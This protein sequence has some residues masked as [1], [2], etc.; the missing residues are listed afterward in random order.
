MRPY[1]PDPPGPAIRHCL[2]VFL[3]EMTIR[4]PLRFQ[5]EYAAIMVLASV[6]V[7]AILMVLG[8]GAHSG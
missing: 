5:L 7:A 8:T 3:S 1:S 6:I 2:P 4:G